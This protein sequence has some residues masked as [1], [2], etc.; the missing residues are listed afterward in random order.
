MSKVISDIYPPLYEL[1]DLFKT[2][3]PGRFYQ[4]QLTK[5]PP[6]KEVDYFF[7]EKVLKTRTVKGKKEYFVKYLYYPNKFNRWI[8]AKNVV[9]KF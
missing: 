9:K 8:P 5:S 4:E 6:P 3:I 1:V 2:Q 7:I